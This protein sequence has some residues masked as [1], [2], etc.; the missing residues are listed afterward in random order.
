[1]ACPAFSDTTQGGG[2][3]EKDIFTP[4]A[5]ERGKVREKRMV[6]TSRSPRLTGGKENRFSP[7]L[8]PQSGKRK[9]KRKRGKLNLSR[10]FTLAY[11]ARG[12]GGGKKGKKI[13][14]IRR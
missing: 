11:S 1:V 2:K 13:T 4:N 9:E 14:L 8:P 7:H 5:H 6:P 3:T 12:G 10:T